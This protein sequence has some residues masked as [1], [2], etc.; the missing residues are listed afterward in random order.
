MILFFSSVKGFQIICVRFNCPKEKSLK[1]WLDL[2]LQVALEF[3][4]DCSFSR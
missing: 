2:V 1:A 3:T 4:T